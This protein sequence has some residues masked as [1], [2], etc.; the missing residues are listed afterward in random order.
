MSEPQPSQLPVNP[1]DNQKAVQEALNKLGT[2][3]RMSM[4]GGAAFTPLTGTPPNG[5]SLSR[6]PSTGASSRASA[7][8]AASRANSRPGTPGIA[9]I[10]N[11]IQNLMEGTDALPLQMSQLDDEIEEITPAEARALSQPGTP[12]F[13][14][15]THAL[16]TLD[17]TTRFIRQSSNLNTRTPSVSGIGTLVEK[18]D[19][20]EAKLVVAM[21]GL[22][23][24]GKS[25]LS[26]KL[27]RYL[28]WLEYKVE[29]FNVGQ[30]RRR[31][32]RDQQEAGE[33][34]TDH[35]ADYFSASNEKATA[36]REELA[37]E[38]LE[39]C[40]DWVKA[41]GNV[42]IMDA[43]NSTFARRR[44]IRERLAKEP[45]L[46]LIF[47]ESYCDDPATIAANI[48]LKASSGDPDY[49][50]MTKEE[51]VADFRKRIAQYESIY[52][53]ISEPDISFC[54][55]LN[56]GQMVTM[57][58]IDSYLQSRIAFYLMNLHLKPR[59][60]YLSRHGESMHNVG[61]MIGGDS[62]I[63][64]RG[65]KYASALPAL[66]LENIGDA[67]IQ[68]WTSTLQRTIATA[69]H[70]PYPKK[71]WKS[72]DELDAGVCDGMTYEEIADKYPEDYEAR[73]DDKFNYRYRGGESYRDVIVRLEP[74]IMELERQDNILIIC[75]QAII[76]CLYGYFMGIP[77]AEIPYIKA[78]SNVP[79]HTLIKLSPR[80]YGCEEER[81]PLPI[82]AVDTHRPKPTRKTAANTPA[83]TPPASGPAGGTARDY[84]GAAAPPAVPDG[85][86]SPQDAVSA[87]AASIKDQQTTQD[88]ADQNG[89]MHK[90]EK[91]TEHNAALHT[92]N[93][94]G[95]FTSAVHEGIDS[96]S[97]A[98]MLAALT[99]QSAARAKD[100]PRLVAF[101]DLDP[102]NWE[103]ELC[104]KPGLDSAEPLQYNKR[105]IYCPRKE[106]GSLILNAGS[107]DM[108][109]D[110]K[111]MPEY[112]KAPFKPDPKV[113]TNGSG[114]KE[115]TLYWHV[116]GSPF[117]FENI[118]FS[119]AIE[120]AN[121]GKDKSIKWLVCAECDLGPLGWC[122]EGDSEAWLSIGRV[123]YGPPTV[124]V[125]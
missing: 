105:R 27:M 76:R 53:T 9:A 82:A 35:S 41:E 116:D 99:A 93:A 61:G 98:A 100:K 5:A 75:H 31:K 86:S 22:P 17:D 20:S 12:H 107:G 80:A 122:Y 91:V 67:P 71:T 45:N 88:Q 54:R 28:R 8:R 111:V 18:P 51:A 42:G 72:L 26:N 44:K 56:V 90:V 68:V 30:L 124:P 32:A 121:K 46:Q 52:D 109:I 37:K 6:Q 74:V 117:A 40:I 106:C 112:E 13:G 34:K 62:P 77:Q 69:R 24:R 60:I 39:S 2:L 43:T 70:L 101:E 7:S 81:Y 15:L 4:S 59:S 119:R 123:N 36:L 73:D 49:A 85:K 11:P 16:R 84:F 29:V 63:S 21:V 1:E 118:G 94:K 104:T 3:R 38:S 92:R 89:E 96:P 114:G 65:E 95:E 120:G 33:Q 19:Y 108:V 23:A 83:R 79:L 97:Q 110:D 87:D 125:Q 58:K 25:Y 113:P 115:A 78:S 64:P 103:E 50:G 66:V 14:A 102:E 55:I 57:N 47:L 48:A 10:Q